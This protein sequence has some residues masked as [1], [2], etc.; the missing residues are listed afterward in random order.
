MKAPLAALLTP[1]LL[2]AYPAADY[3]HRP[4]SS[5]LGSNWNQAGAY[6]DIQSLGIRA[7]GSDT[8]KGI[9]WVG[10]AAPN[11]DQF[12]ITV[13]DS[14]WNA[15]ASGVNGGVAIRYDAT[16]GNGYFCHLDVVSTGTFRI[17]VGKVTANVKTTL[18]AGSGSALTL[19]AGA[20]LR[21][22]AVG[23]SINCILVDSTGA[24]QLSTVS[25]TDSTYTSGRVGVHRTTQNV[26]FAAWFGGDGTG[27]SAIPYNS[28]YT[29]GNY[30]ISLTATN[31]G[32]TGTISDPWPYLAFFADQGRLP[33]GSTLW[34]RG[35]TYTSDR[36]IYKP[37]GALF[38]LSND[39]LSTTATTYRA[40]G[41]ESVVFDANYDCNTQAAVGEQLM[42][43]SGDYSILEGGYLQWRFTN[44]NTACKVLT[45][46]G[47]NPTK[48]PMRSVKANGDYVKLRNL[49]IHDNGEG[50]TDNGANNDGTE[51]TGLLVFN[52]GWNAP[53]REHGHGN[54][55]HNDAWAT[56]QKVMRNGIY[57][58]NY[59][60]QTKLYSQTGA[61]V[62][63]FALSN[64]FFIGGFSTSSP[65]AGNGL[66]FL[67]QGLNPSNVAMTNMHVVDA[68]TTLNAD[69]YQ[70]DGLSL[71][72]SYLDG[73]W[74]IHRTCAATVTGNV[75]SRSAGSNGSAQF[76][77]QYFNTPACDTITEAF[78]PLNNN[79]YYAAR[80]GGND[81]YTG[82]TG[83]PYTNYGFAGWQGLGVDTSSTFNTTT[84]PAVGTSA[85]GSA[86]NYSGA[87]V[88]PTIPNSGIVWVWNWKGLTSTTV[89]VS[90]I[91]RVGDQY[92]IS[93]SQCALC[94]TV[95]TGTYAGGSL[96]F[97]LTLTSIT[98]PSGSYGAD[99]GSTCTAGSDTGT[100]AAHALTSFKHATYFNAFIVRKRTTSVPAVV[101]VVNSRTNATQIK[102]DW[103][104]SATTLDQPPITSSCATGATC[105]FSLPSQAFGITYYRLTYLTAGGATDA[106]G[107]VTAIPVQ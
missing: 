17:I 87:V 85:S 102:L 47:S 9:E 56:V 105:S 13:L 76:S 35:G 86:T 54:Y 92:E 72:N 95:S 93:D 82:V 77:S 66:G 44:S 98:A 104:Y 25:A 59:E 61:S 22:W 57:V 15:K 8:T 97:D 63:N 88:N 67:I 70:S 83:G 69:N 23:T 58:R 49:V 31:A 101:S 68:A 33:C 64:I 40:Y 14:S 106:A 5:S 6:F 41:M 1:C 7:V 39:C 74:N 21:L 78:T 12:S 37:S 28:A 53:D 30:F 52:N 73:G 16:T 10:E 46:C 36:L 27:A 42:L 48:G 38:E 29:A 20:R 24:T 96:T 32:A 91:L 45:Q 34:L 81:F 79:S 94:G 100:A 65:G 3:F 18:T 2:I 90:S 99:P 51:Q 80:T 62:G 4:D 75:F 26:A 103:G 11:N 89:D 84:F 19:S 50:V 71:T 55:A 43:V 107:S 60:Y